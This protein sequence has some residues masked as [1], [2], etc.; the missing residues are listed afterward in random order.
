VP[1]GAQLPNGMR[2]KRTAR[3]WGAHPFR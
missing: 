3:A 1:S 2:I